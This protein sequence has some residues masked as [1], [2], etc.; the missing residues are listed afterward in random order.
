[1]DVKPDHIVLFVT[2]KSQNQGEDLSDILFI[3]QTNIGSTFL[4]R[5]RW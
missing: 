1:M 2:R 3:K 4:K 5:L